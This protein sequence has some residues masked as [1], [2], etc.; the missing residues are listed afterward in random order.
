MKRIVAL[1]V[2]LI[3]LLTGCGINTTLSGEDAVDLMND[4]FSYL[5]DE[6]V[7]LLSGWV[8]EGEDKPIFNY[9]FR[10]D[11]IDYEALK[12]QIYKEY[13]RGFVLEFILV[14][15]P[16]EPMITGIVRKIEDRQILIVA[17][18]SDWN[19]A[20]G[21]PYYDALWVGTNENTEF[22]D[23]DNIKN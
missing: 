3:L 11:E 4:I 14:S 15:F 6:E 22:V 10:E 12:K 16:A 23:F 21:N 17:A 1:L 8:D 5:S 2:C 9:E 20:D 18:T 19:S 13:G 7:G